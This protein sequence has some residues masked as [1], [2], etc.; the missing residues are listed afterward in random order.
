M[1]VRHGLLALLAA[2]PHY[3]AELRAEFERRTGGTWPI[4]IGQVYSTLGRLQRDGLVEP[5]GD[6]TDDY[7]K[8][9][10][11]TAAGREALAHWWDDPSLTNPD[12]RDELTIKLALAVDAD[13][14]DVRDVVQRHR[15]AGIERLRDLTAQK[16]SGTSGLGAELVL[17]RRIFDTEALVRWLDHVED[18]LTTKDGQ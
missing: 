5:V 9:Y 7:R 14:V 8:E 17:E 3:G 11:I 6:G 13:D 16:R 12:P 18:R 2:T 4:N 15:A 1:S 10:A